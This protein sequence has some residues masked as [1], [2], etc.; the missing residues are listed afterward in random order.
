MTDYHINVFYSERDGGDIAD[1]PDLNACTA[2]A[3]TAEEPVREVVA[4]G[5]AG[6]NAAISGR[7]KLP[8]PRCRPAL[9]A[10]A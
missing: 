8:E 5:V 10:S 6:L 7:K 1:V 3:A 4:A 9:Y 2:F